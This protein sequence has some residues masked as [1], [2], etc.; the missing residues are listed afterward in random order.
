MDSRA[1]LSPASY[2]FLLL[3]FFL[4]TH[5]LRN[6]LRRLV[7]FAALQVHAF[8][9]LMLPASK[10]SDTPRSIKLR[11]HKASTRVE[12]RKSWSYLVPKT[13]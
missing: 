5:S 8:E 11:Y 4:F 6:L 10:C 2:R 13:Q 7:D 12:T 9:N 3:S 1:S